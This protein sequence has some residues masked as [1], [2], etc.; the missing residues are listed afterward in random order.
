MAALAALVVA[1]IV[2]LAVH[3]MGSSST[4]GL[5]GRLRRRDGREHARRRAASRLRTRGR[6]AVRL[7]GRREL[8]PGTRR[9]GRSAAGCTL[10]G[11]RLSAVAAERG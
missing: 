6:S 4:P 7:R 8:A 3:G 1:A 11:G 2:G 5:V 9:W 10:P